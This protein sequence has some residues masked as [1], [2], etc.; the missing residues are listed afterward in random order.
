MPAIAA[1]DALVQSQSH[2]SSSAP[3][4]HGPSIRDVGACEDTTFA[5]T[6]AALGLK[7]SQEE[8][9]AHAHDTQKTLDEHIRTQSLGSIRSG[10]P[11][12]PPSQHQLGLDEPLLSPSMLSDIYQDAIS[13]PRMQ[14]STPT[15]LTGPP[16][17]DITPPST[18]DRLRVPP[19]QLLHFP[20]LSQTD[21]FHTARENLRSQ[22]SS[23]SHSHLSNGDGEFSS[24]ASSKRIASPATS[25]MATSLGGVSDPVTPRANGRL[26]K[27]ELSP[28]P[29]SRKASTNDAYDLLDKERLL[30]KPD[31]ARLTG[32]LGSDV[33][34]DSSH[35]RNASI[36]SASKSDSSPRRK[37]RRRRRN[38]PSAMSNLSA[39]PLHRDE[40]HHF[41]TS[42][43]AL[44][45]HLRDE[46]SKRLSAHSTTS[47]IV[48]AMVYT[49]PQRPRR[50]LRHAGKNLAL[51]TDVDVQQHK[52]NLS[53]TT[54][55]HE[56]QL[57]HRKTPLPGRGFGM[58]H[59]GDENSKFR[60]VSTPDILQ[61]QTKDTST[62]SG[63]NPHFLPFRTLSKPAKRLTPPDWPLRTP[64]FPAEQNGPSDDESIRSVEQRTRQRGNPVD[65]TDDEE[66]KSDHGLDPRGM[67]HPRLGW[68]RDRVDD[69]LASPP[70]KS[71]VTNGY[72]IPK[73][74]NDSLDISDEKL[75][76]Y[77][78][79]SGSDGG[80]A[81]GSFDG[82][83]RRG[84]LEPRMDHAHARNLTL[85]H[86]PLSSHSAWS[87][88]THIAEV[89]Q[90]RAVNIYPH[91]NESILLIQQQSQPPHVP[92]APNQPHKET[93]P[94]SIPKFEAFLDSGT[95]PPPTP[96]THHSPLTN[97]RAAPVPPAIN[98]IPP[99]PASEADRQLA[100][101][102]EPFKMNSTAPLPPK[103]RDSLRQRARA[104]SAA[105]VDAVL[106]RNGA[107]V[108]RRNTVHV[109]ERPRNLHPFWRPRGFWEDFDSD[110]DDDEEPE[111]LPRGGDDSDVQEQQEWL[112]RRMSRRVGRSLSLQSRRGG[113][114]TGR[115]WVPGQDGLVVKRRKSVRVMRTGMGVGGG[116]FGIGGKGFKGLADVRGLKGLRE[117]TGRIKEEREER[118][119]ERRRARIR[120]SIGAKW[121]QE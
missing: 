76:P 48:E 22:A 38:E 20:S 18:R 33:G 104:Q 64:P 101:S 24:G 88:R 47:T 36:N 41:D 68:R 119:R 51:R 110:E 89:N 116:G 17:P 1:G 60:S 70:L 87:D 53:D 72:P 78:S 31:T 63:P 5:G 118:A 81:W 54:A 93:P 113:S 13:S 120:G 26:R 80:V 62:A 9:Y 107:Q 114:G 92:L 6:L 52:R 58:G 79:H 28:S 115:S 56:H 95:P 29:R 2:P 43:D 117:W 100:P 103:R 98:F 4:G 74:R 44:Y 46:K 37:A 14:A 61:S 99:T 49:S 27:E 66:E 40:V 57:R 84:S 69:E 73:P 10:L 108:R 39:D 83:S 97:P 86:T 67:Q 75:H 32:H 112:P 34:T 65:L 109:D 96:T 45:T 21:S 23:R 90:A 55:L 8:I 50:G 16:T 105:F 121:V 19:K 111:P 77:R 15:Q 71:P 94:R 106:L 35:S 30:S 7:L 59:L 102:P 85:A 3:A 11:P 91:N 42:H 82:S 12:T 25:E